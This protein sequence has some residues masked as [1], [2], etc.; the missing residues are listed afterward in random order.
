VLYGSS[1]LQTW[2]KDS[3]INLT[4]SGDISILMP[5]W[6]QEIKADGFSEFADGHL[7]QDATLDIVIDLGTHIATSTSYSS[8]C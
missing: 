3:A 4:A 6:Q 8:C 5:G 7:T 2:R 1:H